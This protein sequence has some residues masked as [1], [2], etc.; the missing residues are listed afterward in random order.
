MPG[1]GSIVSA[2]A[3][4]AGQRPV[5]IGKPSQVLAEAL[6]QVT[7]IPAEQTMFVGDRVSTDIAMAH[8]AG[9]V[10]VLVLTGVARDGDAHNA[11][12]DYVIRDL[13]QLSGFS[14]ELTGCKESP[15][16]P[17]RLET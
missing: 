7:G 4:A 3:T 6:A 16:I 1:A 15:T 9:M 8:A 13:S 10:S 12:A 14:D 2:V 17:E 5:S 11:L